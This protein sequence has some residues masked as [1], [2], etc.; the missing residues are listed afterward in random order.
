MRRAPDELARIDRRFDDALALSPDDRQ[1]F[2]ERIERTE[3][4]LA[5]DVRAL[6]Q[7]ADQPEGTALWRAAIDDGWQGIAS[8]PAD[9]RCAGER[10]GAYRIVRLLGRGG[11]APVY[12][13]E[14]ADGVFTQQVALKLV[15]RD[16]F[17]AEALD[18]FSRERQILAHLNHPHIARL[19]DGGVDER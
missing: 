18:R 7:A 1:I 8:R 19:L 2:L 17:G 13:A 4:L 10:I 6:L 14:R 5:V 16:L 15:T 9:E 11:M 3:P 12:L